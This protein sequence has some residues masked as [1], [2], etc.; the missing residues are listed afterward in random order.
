MYCAKSV[1]MYRPPLAGEPEIEAVAQMLAGGDPSPQLV[2]DLKLQSTS[3]ESF[4]K[5]EANR[6]T[7]EDMRGRLKRA[8]SA[9]T[10]LMSAL[11]DPHTLS[12]I[13]RGA[14]QFMPGHRYG[15]FF[16][17]LQ[18]IARRAERA[19][20]MVRAKG[21]KDR[22][23]VGVTVPTAHTY[24]ALVIEE[25]WLLFKGSKPK[26][27]NP[28]AHA[29]AALFW[30]VCGGTRERSFGDTNSGWRKHFVAASKVLPMQR[31]IV[32]QRFMATALAKAEHRPE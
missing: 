7:R 12:Y 26:A 18:D 8:Q 1:D 11:G 14:E 29:A 16:A 5:N 27:S 17:M 28:E 9:A 20:E 21:G 15:P 24:C 4:L 30:S 10:D 25:A 32:R 31:D 2:S 13:E 23:H 6:P 3:L 19:A 22:A